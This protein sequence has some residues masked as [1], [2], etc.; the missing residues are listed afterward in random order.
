MKN[1]E[2]QKYIEY[3]KKIMD[4]QL[5]IDNLKKNEIITNKMQ[6]NIKNYENEKSIKE[7]EKNAINLEDKII[8]YESKACNLKY[9]NIV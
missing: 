5:Y 2:R 8:N 4:Y 3:E 7:K 1:N 9:S 6:L